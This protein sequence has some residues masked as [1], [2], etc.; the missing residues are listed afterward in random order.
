[1]GAP[2]CRSTRR[3][4]VF[5]PAGARSGD[6]P[7]GPARGCGSGRRSRAAGGPTGP[8]H[9]DCRAQRSQPRRGR[10]PSGPPAR[11]PSRARLGGP[12]VAAGCPVSGASSSAADSRA[13]SSRTRSGPAVTAVSRFTRRSRSVWARS[14]LPATANGRARSRR[15]VASAASWAS[16]ATTTCTGSRRRPA[17]RSAIAATSIGGGRWPAATRRRHSVV[18]FRLPPSQR[19][20][21]PLLGHHHLDRS[22]EHDVRGSP[23]GLHQSLRAGAR[24]VRRRR[25][26]AIRAAGSA[27]ATGPASR[28]RCRSSR[29]AGT[30]GSRCTSTPTA[31]RISSSSGSRAGSVAGLP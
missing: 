5:L 23:V 19:A 18:H 4:T 31:S 21:S 7:R 29:G 2:T 20:G 16:R 13:A 26:R 28:V 12:P 24:V 11:A 22:R 30:P 10:G 9:R 1:M 15:A 14:P 6:R 27:V 25:C 8:G 3:V 17:R